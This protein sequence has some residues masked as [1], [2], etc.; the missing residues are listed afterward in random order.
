MNR[1]LLVNRRR[2]VG[3]QDIGARRDTLLRYQD[4]RAISHV[5]NP[6]GYWSIVACQLVFSQGPFAERRCSLL[7]PAPS[8]ALRSSPVSKEIRSDVVLVCVVSSWVPL[9]NLARSRETSQLIA[10]WGRQ[11]ST[12]KYQYAASGSLLTS[13]LWLYTRPEPA[14][15][16]ANTHAAYR[17][18]GVLTWHI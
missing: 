2:C 12:G 8:M 6:P 1:S 4:I 14:R 3:E 9:N 5:P 7:V 10:R 17:S 16:M 18:L 13:K 15:Y 11:M